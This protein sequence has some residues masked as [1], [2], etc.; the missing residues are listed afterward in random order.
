[1]LIV[2]HEMDFAREP[3]TRVAVMDDGRIV[4][5][6]PPEPVLRHAAARSARRRFLSKLL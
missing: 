6:A 2:T 5:E 1:M 4:E 3:P